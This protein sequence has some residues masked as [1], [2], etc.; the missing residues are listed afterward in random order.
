MSYSLDDIQDA[1]IQFL[2]DNIPQPVYEDY[3][4]NTKTL[5]RDPSGNV[6]PYVVV[7]FGDLQPQYSYA[8]TGPQDDDY[9]L[10]IYVQSISSDAAT[11]RKISNLVVRR[12]LG[13][14]TP[15]GGNVRKKAGFQ[16]FTVDSSDGSIEAYA[17]PAF[18][19]LQ[20]QLAEVED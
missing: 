7:Q 9:G 19:N 3:I 15:W 6:R 17:S 2:R 4:P 14:T 10:P 18:F 11:S 20:I 12:F 16:Y 5:R 8:M 13:W 1:A